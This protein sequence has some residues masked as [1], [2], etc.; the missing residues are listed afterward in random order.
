MIVLHGLFDLRLGVSV[1]DFRSAFQAFHG[2]LRTKH[3]VRSARFMRH[4]PHGGYDSS[5][6]KTA[7]YI[8]MEFVDREQAERCWSYVEADREPLHTLHS[9]MNKLVQ[10]ARFFFYSDVWS[11]T[12]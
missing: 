3:F 6:P 8:A 2:H 10:T 9:S 4:E 7:F 11:D 1:E 5:P 12:V